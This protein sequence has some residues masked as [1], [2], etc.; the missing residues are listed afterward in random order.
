MTE[1]ARPLE[2]QGGEATRL[3]ALYADGSDAAIAEAEKL[4]LGMIAESATWLEAG[5]DRGAETVRQWW[6]AQVRGL[7]GEEEA[8]E[9]DQRWALAF[10]NAKPKA[11]AEPEAKAE[12]KP[13]ARLASWPEP[14]VAPPDAGLERLTYP[15][16]LLGH[17][18]QYMVD[19]S[20]LP[21]RWLSLACSVVCLWPRASI[22]R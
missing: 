2:A 7:Y 20:P 12:S 1:A 3:I 16:G 19:T 13:R 22:A 10:E 6:I 18:A 14:P 11:K 21:N 17:V 4:T 9:F 8:E 15:R 5:A